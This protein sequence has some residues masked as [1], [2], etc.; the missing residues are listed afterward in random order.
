MKQP[1]IVFIMSD[2]HAYQA[3]SC[4]GH[5]L[6]ETPHIDRIAK[7]GIRFDRCYCTNSICTPSR[8][9]ILTGQ[10]NHTNGVRTLHDSLDNTRQTFPKL[11]QKAGYQT[12]IVG[13]WHLGHGEKHDPTGFDYWNVLPGQG[14]YHNPVFYEMGKEVQY[15]GY[16]TD[17]ITEKSIE[18]MEQRDKEKPFLLM[19]HHKAPH[20]PWEPADKYKNLYDDIEF[21]YP[22]TFDDDYSTRGRAAHKAK[23]RIED[24]KEKDVKAKT[25][26]GLTL[27]EEKRWKYQRYIKDYLRCIASVDDSV[28]EILGYLEK[29]GIIDNTL[30][31]YTSDQGFYLG[32]HGWFD[33]RFMYEE[34]FRMPFI[35]RYPKEISA[36]SISTDFVMNVDFAPTF[37]EYAGISIPEDMQGESIRPLLQG[38]LPT[39]WRKTIYYRYWECDTPEQPSEHNVFPHYGVRTDRYKLIYYYTHGLDLSVNQEDGPIAPEWE[40]Y[41]LEKDPAELNN[42]YGNPGYSQEI[43]SLKEELERIRQEIGDHE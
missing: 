18:W 30:I 6:N 10:Y 21:P 34:S 41:D 42:V 11:L 15:E 12:A 31:I 38:E 4:Y 3:M 24:L 17:L 13:K 36:G 43:Q 22:D 14:L 27:A 32:E 19:C 26:A 35:V 9:T 7:E 28:G 37:L 25:P 16:A 33:K 8:A 39:D 40:F 29:E 23:M 1:N 2:D 5:G 20:R